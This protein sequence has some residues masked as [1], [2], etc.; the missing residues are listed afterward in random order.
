MYN[1]RII[2]IEQ[3]GFDRIVLFEFPEKI[4]ILELFSKGN[5]VLCD[6]EMNI[7]KASRKETWKDRSLEI[8]AEY[9]FPSS[10]GKNPLEI[11][12][13]EFFGELQKNK[14]TFF[15]AV[16]DILNVAPGLLDE[17]FENSGFD[18][19]KN[20]S[21]VSEREAEKLLRMVIELYSKKEEGAFVK[22]GVIYSVKV[23]GET[24]N[25]DNVTSALNVLRFSDKK[26]AILEEKKVERKIDYAAQTEKALMEEKEFK[27]IGEAIYLH[28]STEIK[29]AFLCPL[30]E[31]S[32]GRHTG[33]PQGEVCLYSGAYL[34]WTAI[35]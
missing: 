24:T 29:Y 31:G 19:K 10:K 7:L 6:K 18:K 32:A 30:H 25:F 5:I 1:Q 8:G 22:E 4:L 34:A 26:T 17:L 23:S 15:G 11:T 3:R 21:E 35:I 20:A 33:K 12:A 14:K 9:K 2:K 28:Y 13:K 27:S 16:V